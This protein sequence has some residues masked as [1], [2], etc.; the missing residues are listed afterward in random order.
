MGDLRNKIAKLERDGA[1]RKLMARL[2]PEQPPPPTP[3]CECGLTPA[4]VPIMWHLKR[5]HWDLGAFY[6]PA[7]LPNKLK[8]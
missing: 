3:R 6:C 8:P 1:H 4:E 7:C 2:H 5:D